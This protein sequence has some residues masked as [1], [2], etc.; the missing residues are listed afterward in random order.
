MEVVFVKLVNEEMGLHCVEGGTE[1]DEQGSSIIL[2][3]L[4]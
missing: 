3:A 4:V 2:L 1:I